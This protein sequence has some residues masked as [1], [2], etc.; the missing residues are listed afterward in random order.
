MNLFWVSP[1]AALISVVGPDFGVELELRV[2]VGVAFG[3]AV[4]VDVGG[5]ARHRHRHADPGVSWNPLDAL[6]GNPIAILRSRSGFFI[7]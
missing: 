4:A 7:I 3:V 5:F 2:A 6:P 1:C